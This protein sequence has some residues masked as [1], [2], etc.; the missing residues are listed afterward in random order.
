MRAAHITQATQQYFVLLVLTDG[1]ITDMDATISAIV[2]AV[3]SA[4]ALDQGCPCHT[5]G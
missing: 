2:A 5:E 4:S 1:V 3:S